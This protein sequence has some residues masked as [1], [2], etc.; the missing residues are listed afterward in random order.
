MRGCVTTRHLITH[1]G[2][3]MREFGLKTYLRCL[4]RCLHSPGEVTFLE[5]IGCL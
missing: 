3:I 5:C 4:Y 1:A 2:L